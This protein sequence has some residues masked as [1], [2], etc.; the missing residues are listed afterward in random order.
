MNNGVPGGCYQAAPSDLLL[1]RDNCHS[2]PL[3]EKHKTQQQQHHQ[4]QLQDK[5]GAVENNNNT[6]G[7]QSNFSGQINIQ[8]LHN[9]LLSKT[10]ASE[11]II[12]HL[13]NLQATSIDSQMLKII[14][15]KRITISI[16]SGLLNN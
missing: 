7:Q 15:L 16:L 11:A 10:Q 6:V 8:D 5:N 14:L 12:G 3:S 9:D 13:L 2:P 1:D 4:H